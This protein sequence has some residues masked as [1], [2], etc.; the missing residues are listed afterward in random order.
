LRARRAA[1]EDRYTLASVAQPSGTLA[2]STGRWA[3]VGA[4]I[5]LIAAVGGLALA[6]LARRRQKAQHQPHPKI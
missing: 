4:L 5:G 6:G 1:A 3:L 2:P